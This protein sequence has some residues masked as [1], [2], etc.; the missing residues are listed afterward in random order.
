[1]TKL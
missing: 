1:V